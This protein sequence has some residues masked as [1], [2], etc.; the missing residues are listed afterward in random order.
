MNYE[1]L[2]ALVNTKVY[3]N[4]EREITG[5]G[6]N[7]V[8]QS[9]VTSLK[10]GYQFAGIA[11]PSTNPGMPDQKVFYIANG[12]GTYTN[13]G[14][15]NVTEDEVIFLVLDNAWHKAATGIATDAKLKEAVTELTEIAGKINT[16]Q[17]KLTIDSALSPT[18]TNPI[19]NKAVKEALD[20]KQDKL[21]IDSALSPTSTNPIQNKVVKEALDAKQDRMTIDSALSATSANPV[22]NKAVKEALDAKQDKLAI[23]S[24][25]SPTST[26]PIQN[27]EQGSEGGP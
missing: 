13:F 22:Q 15:I 12:K 2:K 23:D 3:E 19:Q 10:K 20:A 26:N 16:K 8:L 7:V 27:K 5:E 25:L 14:G 21:T 18:S 9:I 17:D 6:L 1:N 4:T 24:A 11:T